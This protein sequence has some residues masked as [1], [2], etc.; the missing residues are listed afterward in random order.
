MFLQKFNN[1]FY[2]FYILQVNVFNIYVNQITT[3]EQSDTYT[4]DLLGGGTTNQ[5]T[6]L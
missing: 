1:K 5:P 4:T 6:T 3:N 2:G